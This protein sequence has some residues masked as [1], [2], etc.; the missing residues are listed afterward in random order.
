MKPL[1]GKHAK[2]SKNSKAL[3]CA[4]RYLMENGGERHAGEIYYNMKFLNGNYYRNHRNSFNKQQLVSKMVRHPAFTFKRQCATKRNG[5]TYSCDK[6][7][8][9]QYF[10]CDPMARWRQ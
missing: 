10:E 5:G 1:S 6:D 8:Y 3:E 9:N 4:A 2:K 7:K